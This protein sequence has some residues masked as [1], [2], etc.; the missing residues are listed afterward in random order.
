MHEIGLFQGRYGRQRVVLL[1]EEGV[2]IP[3]N[4]A[5]VVYISFPKQ[6]IEA[7]FYL[8]QRELKEMYA[9]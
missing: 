7:G 8:L 3:T 4:L 9:L 5:G 6:S 2:S 1:H